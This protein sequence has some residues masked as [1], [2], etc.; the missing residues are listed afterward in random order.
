MGL[1]KEPLDIDFVVDSRKLSAA[2]ELAICNYIKN[3]KAK[4]LDF[5]NKIKTA[6]IKTRSKILA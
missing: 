2:E 6:R 5:Q 4:R 1:I 3:D